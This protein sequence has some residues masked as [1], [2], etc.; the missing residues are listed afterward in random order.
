MVKADLIGV[1]A[2]LAA[3]FPSKDRGSAATLADSY[4]SALEDCGP[5]ELRAAAQRVMREDRF[6]PRPARLRELVIG[7]RDGRTL[8]PEYMTL[9]QRHAAWMT[10]DAYCHDPCPVCGSMVTE[11]PTGRL[12]M[13]H[14]RD[15]HREAGVPFSGYLPPDAATTRGQWISPVTAAPREPVLVGTVLADRVPA[16]A[17]TPEAIS[18]SKG[19]HP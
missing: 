8:A 18:H 3:V 19:Q 2:E 6:F 7:N 16:L 11:R 15:R 14:D 17:P 9:A 13:V 1:M 12:A 4:Y 10:S 5:Q